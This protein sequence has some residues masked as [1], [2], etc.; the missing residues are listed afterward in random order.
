MKWNINVDSTSVPHQAFY[1]D[2]LTM[3]CN[4]SNQLPIAEMT[5]TTLSPAAAS[6]W[7]DTGESGGAAAEGF[8]FGDSGGFDSFLA[9]NEPPPVPQSTPRR[10]ARQ[11]SGDSDDEPMTVV[12]KCVLGCR[13]GLVAMTLS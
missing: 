6:P 4:I 9:M 13:A 11:T 8:G 2:I 5:P 3:H 12:I 7:G 10:A 1:T